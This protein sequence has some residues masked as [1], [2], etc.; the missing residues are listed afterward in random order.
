MRYP[1]PR[2]FALLMISLTAILPAARAAEVT[3][4]LPADMHV[5]LALKEPLSGKRNQATVGQLVK[6]AVW[7][8]VIVGGTTLIPAGTPAVCKVDDIRHA[9]IAGV[10]G[11]MSIGA[12]E[13]TLANG[14]TIPLRG[15]Y[16]KEGE[17]RKALSITLGVLFLVPILIPGSAAELPDGMV[18]D[19][20]TVQATA[21]K[22]ESGDAKAPPVINLANLAS[23][24]SADV[25]YAAFEK[26]EK[27]KV[28]RINLAVDGALPKEF[29]I[30]TVNGNPVDPIPLAI[31]QSTPGA[32]GSTAVGEVGIKKLL[33]H[34]IKGIN[35]FDVSYQDDTGRHSTEVILNIQI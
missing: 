25:D 26:E 20:Y 7:R 1:R 22:V 27:P 11:K 10:E 29:V 32:E 31:T 24:F 35:R 13:I 28:F 30:D 19:A 23:G 3:Q 8:D 17:G 6:C 21:L 33:K 15:G 5:Y 18:F 14:S 4:T 9:Q 34:F 16:M 12:Q 2:A